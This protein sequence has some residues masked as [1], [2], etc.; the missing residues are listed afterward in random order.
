MLQRLT[1]ASGNDIM[2]IW[3]SIKTM[4]SDLCK[5]NKMLASEISKLIG[6]SWVPGQLFCV[7]HYVL[8]IPESIKATF[9]LYQGQIGRDKLFP[10]TTDFEMNIN[11]K[12]VV[13]QILEIWLHL[14][15]CM[16]ECEAGKCQKF[17]I[18]QPNFLIL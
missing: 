15:S 12:V 13:V 9:A 16:A 5:V 14:T 3:E 2:P 4:L 1:V 8:T 6:S 17:L 10:E 11:D 18:L 7:L